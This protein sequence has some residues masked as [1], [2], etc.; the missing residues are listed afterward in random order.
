MIGDVTLAKLVAAGLIKMHH[1]T[2]YRANARIVH[3]I[4]MNFGPL[5]RDVNILNPRLTQ[6]ALLEKHLTVLSSSTSMDP[7]VIVRRCLL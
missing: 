5:K 6:H 3:G 2:N 4:R 1:S 7:S